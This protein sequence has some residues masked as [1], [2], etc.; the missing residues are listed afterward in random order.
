LRPT[1]SSELH[2]INDLMRQY[3]NVPM[4]FAGATL[5]NLANQIKC[6]SIFTLDVSDFS[7]YRPARNISFT[8]YPS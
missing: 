1:E 3:Q 5:V 8:I 6:Y 4:D 7:I 2:T